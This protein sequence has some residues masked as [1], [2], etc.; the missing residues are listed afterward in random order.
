MWE[1]PGGKVE[2]GETDVEALIRECE[3]ELGV[4]V[5]VGDRVGGDVLLGHGRA[6][7]RVFAARL[8][9][10][11]QPQALEHAELRWLAADQLD[12]VQWLPAD[13]PIVTALGPL[14][15]TPPSPRT[16]PT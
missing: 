2:P 8:L 11:E 7:L 14:L 5:A 13:A 4:R 6:V 3:E 16:P 9:D 1:F 12:S 10:G 15:L